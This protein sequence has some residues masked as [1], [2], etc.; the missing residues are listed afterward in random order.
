MVPTLSD[1]ALTMGGYSLWNQAGQFP[2]SF[3]EKQPSN[4]G[5]H[6]W[7]NDTDKSKLSVYKVL[8]EN[9]LTG[10]FSWRQQSE[11][12]AHIVHPSDHLLYIPPRNGP[13]Y[14]EMSAGGVEGDGAAIYWE[15]GHQ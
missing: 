15:L 14:S 6:E 4:A 13:R 8:I 1:S 5:T 2:T 11:M 9:V 3:H 7:K 10:S 12:K